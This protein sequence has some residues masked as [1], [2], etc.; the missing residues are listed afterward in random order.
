MSH[1][2][3]LRGSNPEISLNEKGFGRNG[4]PC[5]RSTG[6][7]LPQAGFLLETIAKYPLMIKSAQI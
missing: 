6:K 7:R 5:G 1:K 4:F 2:H 3:L